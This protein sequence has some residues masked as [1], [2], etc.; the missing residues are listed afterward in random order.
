MCKI[1]EE[2]NLIS[3]LSLENKP[4][5]LLGAGC[6]VSSGCM[7]ASALV[8]DFKKRI[9]CEANGLKFQDSWATNCDALKEKINQ[10]ISNPTCEPDYSYFFKACF[11]T[12][13]SRNLFI[14]QQFQNKSPSLGYLCFA[15][16][17]IEHSIHNVLTTNFDHLVR[18]SVVSLDENYDVAD[19][20]DSVSPILDNKLV[21]TN[22]H[23]DYNYDLVQNTSEELGSLTENVISKFRKMNF[24]SLV[25]IG[26]SGADNS[27]ISALDD[28]LRNNPTVQL[29]WVV[30]GQTNDLPDKVKQMLSYCSESALVH[31][32]GFDDIFLKYYKTFGKS[33]PLIDGRVESKENGQ[34]LFANPARFAGDIETNAFSCTVEPE[35]SCIENCGQ[36]KISDD[37]GVYYHESFFGF[38]D[39]T[40]ETKRIQL[41]DTGLPLRI[42]EIVISKLISLS[43]KGKGLKIYGRHIYKEVGAQPYES[44]KYCVSTL[45]GKIVLTLEPTFTYGREPNQI[46]F[47]TINSK[48]ATIFSQKHEEMLIGLKK[49][50][51]GTSLA[52]DYLSYHVAFNPLPIKL[53]ENDNQFSTTY[54]LIGEPM[55]AINNRQSH[56]QIS[57][58]FDHG[59]DELLYAP[60]EIKIGVLC[61]QED[62]KRLFAF[63]K[64]L[65]NGLPDE[66]R[67]TDD[68]VRAFPGFSKLTHTGIKFTGDPEY[69]PTISQL[70]DMTQEQLID[71]VVAWI[72]RIEEKVHPDLYL[73]FF[74]NELEKFR[75]VD[76][77]DFHDRLKFKCL[78]SYKT[79]LIDEKK[80]FKANLDKGKTLFNLSVAIY[81][82]T[83][84]MPWKPLEYNPNKFF[85]G[86]AFGQ[87]KNGINLSCSQLFDGAGRGM[88]LLVS[89]V[90]NKC[91][92][93]PYLSKDEAYHLGSKIREVYYQSSMPFELESIVI[94]R[95]VPFKHEEIEGF[96][97][98]FSG[99]K[100]FALLQIIEYSDF[101]GYSIFNNTVFGYPQRRGTVWKIS[102]DEAVLW[103]DG[104]VKED[105]V[106]PRRNYRVSTRG[107]ATPI[108]IRKFYGTQS[109][110][111]IACDI[112]KLSKMDFNSA[113]SLYSRLPVTLKFA[114]K[115]SSILKNE[116]TSPDDQLIDF[117]YIM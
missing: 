19:S 91:Q 106:I 55:M 83:I 1:L 43:V 115:L 17:L 24:N 45:A 4:I 90:S 67:R 31:S 108:M 60:K 85:L 57:L 32:A 64:E 109:I 96:K 81:T 26:Y 36:Q 80:T 69:K 40:S 29:F 61:P 56:N 12:R 112:L 35:I 105:D 63:L 9:Y 84:G 114:K 70:S 46:E 44:L 30:L 23:G 14:K 34:L 117:K 68:I 76:G 54:S 2:K 5:F 8:F 89:P 72:R 95:T 92:K 53:S 10:T 100:N 88:K 21:I 37:L 110:E 65:E 82:K 11:P 103:T 62:K 16:Y 97:Q 52:F 78:S 49:D 86:M 99:L 58:L 75:T 41:S 87:S 38:A 6:S 101:S 18:K 66:Q 42:Q 74:P 59:P 51:F 79:Q 98:A 111:E 93:N 77:V 13:E 71:F 94:H 20:S 7:A 104:S 15:N 113:A 33:N 73:V 102:D 27:V 50:F 47:L 3:I 107:V 25:V 39:Q 28:Y 116:E 48:L 22:L